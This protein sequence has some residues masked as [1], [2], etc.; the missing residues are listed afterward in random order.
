[1]RNPAARDSFYNLA[2]PA[3]EQALVL[4][5]MDERIV[6][7]LALAYDALHRC[8]E[9]EQLYQ[10]ALTMDPRSVSLHKYY[11]GHADCWQPRS[12]EQPSN[13]K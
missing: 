6:L 3:F 1:M 12:I 11:E 10:R 7:E 4:A 2:I 5:P 13:Q 8:D 9:A